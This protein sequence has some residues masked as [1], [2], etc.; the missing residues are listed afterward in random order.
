M[1]HVRPEDVA[2]LQPWVRLWHLWVSVAFLKGYLAQAREASFLP[3]NRAE[4]SLLLDLYLLKRAANELRYELV[5]HPD[6]V[7]VPLL[8]LLE[9][10]ETKD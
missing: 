6:R 2:A 3:A 1:G 4:Q 9:L 10:L 8:G 5:N 7:D